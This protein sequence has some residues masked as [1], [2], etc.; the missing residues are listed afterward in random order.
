M[1][2][3]CEPDFD[4]GA[5]CV[6]RYG[7]CAVGLWCP[8][9][10]SMPMCELQVQPGEACDRDEECTSGRCYQSDFCLASPSC[11]PPA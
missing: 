8:S 10:T 9:S 3:T 11:T 1:T 6:S 5:E 2:D 4:A 7:E